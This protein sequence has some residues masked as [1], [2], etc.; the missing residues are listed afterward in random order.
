VALVLFGGAVTDRFER[1]LLVY[2]QILWTTMLQRLVPRTLLGRVASVD[3]LLSWGLTP[4][5]YAMTPPLV[6]AI[7][8]DATLVAAGCAAAG[9]LVAAYVLF[10]DMRAVE[11][12]AVQ[13][14]PAATSA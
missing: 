9:V 12:G 10:P 11:A 3:S 2:G 6:H 13:T 7:G 1:R 4:V 5:S 14:T 8:L